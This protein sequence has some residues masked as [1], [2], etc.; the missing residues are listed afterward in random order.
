MN[1]NKKLTI[2]VLLILGI[3]NSIA[4]AQIDPKL[5]TVNKNDQKGVYYNLDEANKHI[6]DVIE[7]NLSTHNLDEIPRVLLK[8][9]N[10]KVLDL[11]D[12]N[13]TNIPGWIGSFKNL[14]RLSLA[15][16]KIEIFSNSLLKIKKLTNLDLRANNIIKFESLIN[17]SELEEIDLSLN[18]IKSIPDDFRNLINL[19]TLRIENN[20]LTMIPPVLFQMSKLQYVYFYK[21]NIRGFITTSNVHQNLKAIYLNGNPIENLTLQ[22]LRQLLPNCEVSTQ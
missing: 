10:L 11:S 14:E 2:A 8:Y 4:K 17:I 22:K 18:K 5:F 7:L 3:F 6:A 15:K 16:N 19:K 13:I 9:K 20:S 1:T 12:N 21:N